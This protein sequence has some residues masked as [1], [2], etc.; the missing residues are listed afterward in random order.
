MTNVRHRLIRSSLRP[1]ER[2][3][4]GCS[5]PV[6]LDVVG[7]II[8]LDALLVRLHIDLASAD[9]VLQVSNR[10]TRCFRN[11]I[12]NTYRSTTL[13]PIQMVAS[14]LNSVGSEIDADGVRAACNPC[15]TQ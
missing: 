11:S 6:A 4:F 10:A 9:C 15:Q 7:E 2:D 3:L 13:S 8:Q 1:A 5:L 12:N 14:H